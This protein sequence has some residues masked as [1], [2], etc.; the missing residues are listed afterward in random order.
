[1]LCAGKSS[2]S[3]TA[4]CGATALARSSPSTRVGTTTRQHWRRAS[5]LRS[6]FAGRATGDRWRIAR[7]NT[8][9]AGP[10]RRCDAGQF[11][12]STRGLPTHAADFAPPAPIAPLQTILQDWADQK[13]AARVDPELV[14]G[15]NA[16]EQ[17]LQTLGDDKLALQP[18][19]NDYRAANLLWHGDKIA[20]VLDFEDLS[21]GY[22]VHDLARAAIHLGT[23][24]HHWG[25]VAQ[26][27]HTAFLESYAA[28][29]PLTATEQAWLPLLLTVQGINL[30]GSAKGPQYTASV[31]S[32]NTYRRLLEVE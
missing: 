10:S 28:I 24:F 31:N 6:S 17:R 14:A 3:I 5:T 1:M 32:V 15:L 26:E 16:I 13:R 21:W 22:R 18:V 25:P 11:A 12:Q 23:R 30:V 2:Q 8:T 29:H 7:S 9:D 4:A 19:H 20:A 27:V